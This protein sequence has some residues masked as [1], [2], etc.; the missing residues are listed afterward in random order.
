MQ[1]GCLVAHLY[2]TMEFLSTVASPEICKRVL[3]KFRVLYC[4][5]EDSILSKQTKTSVEQCAV[6]FRHVCNQTATLAKRISSSW[7]EDCI[8]FLKDD[9]AYA[10]SEMVDRASQST[11]F[12]KGL[13]V[14]LDWIRQLAE[15]CHVCLWE[16]ENVKHVRLREAKERA[17]AAEANMKIAGLAAEKKA[18]SA[19]DTQ[20]AW[21]IASLIPIVN[22][23]AIPVYI[24][25]RSDTEKAQEEKSKAIADRE[26]SVIQSK[27]KTDEEKIKVCM[28]D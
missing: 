11:E 17:I 26:S 25:C 28:H 16:I 19:E 24:S 14:I 12:V 10:S 21:G 15:R 23:V 5:S 20:F 3:S 18:R 13:A 9:K 2:F 22:L 1:F 4:Y 6:D 27:A 8:L 7:I